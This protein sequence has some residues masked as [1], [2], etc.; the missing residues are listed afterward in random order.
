MRWTAIAAIAAIAT[1]TAV[2]SAAPQQQP[3]FRSG[4][5]LVAVDVS[6]IDKTGKPVD[7][8][9][10]ADF[11]L[12]VDGKPRRLSSA[13]FVNLRRTD[14][15]IDPERAKYSTNQGLK[16]GRL[17]LIVIDEGNIHKGNGRNVLAA[18]SKFIDGLN[19]SDRVSVEFVPGTGP[20][21]G[22]TANHAL[23]KELL[24]NGVGKMVEAEVTRQVGL[25]EAFTFVREGPESRVYL[26]MI[27]RECLG[28]R[29]STSNV[30]QCKLDLVNRARL[31]YQTARA[32]AANS[33][34]SLRAI[35]QRLAVSSATPKTLVLMTEGIAI[36]RD[37]A[38][39][40]WVAPLS[41]LAQIN[42][43][44][45]QIDGSFTDASMGSQSP[46]HYAD[47][48]LYKEGLDRLTNEA[49]GVVLPVAV[50]ATSAFARLDLE[51][52]GYYLLSFEPDLV[53]RD[54]K[55]HGI[56]VKVTRPGVTV[57][58]R[59]Q[60]AV[61]PPPGE[62][63]VDEQLVDALKNPLPVSD[64]GLKVTTFTYRDDETRKLKV[65]VST[66]IDRSANPAGDFV[67]GYLVT[68]ARGARVGS[69]FEKALAVP[70]KDDVGRPQRYT[71]AFVVDPGIYSVKV[72]VV[73]P[74]GR[75]GSVERTFNAKLATAGQLRIGELMLAEIVGRVARP[76][77][78]GRINADSLMAY[79]EIYADTAAALQNATVA[80]EIGKTENDAAVERATLKFSDR[81]FEG[82][83]AAEGAVPIAMLP[84]GDYIARAVATLDGKIVGQ[85]TRPFTVTHAEA[86]TPAPGPAPVTSIGAAGTRDAAGDRITFTSKIDDFDRQAVLS[87]RVVS[88]FVDRMN[89][90]GQPQ[91]PAGLAPSIAA[92][93]AGRFVDLQQAL[94]TAPAHPATMFLAG[95]AKMSQGDL[96]TAETSLRDALK[97]SPAFF[98][99]AFYLGASYAATGRDAD[100]VAIWQTALIT[101]AG[102]PFVY[103][104]LG[105][106]ML[107][108]HHTADA[109][110][111][112]REAAILWP[113]V[114]D[115]TM[116]FG[117]ALAQG[118]QAADALKVLEPYLEKHAADQDGLM[119]AMRLLYEARSANRPIDS[120]E[121][122]RA[123]FNRY[124]DAYA[125]TNGPQLALARQ[126]KAII[127]K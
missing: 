92:A 87:P 39:L 33:L 127:D 8:L 42:V 105:D 36:D 72:A 37:A 69:Q 7:N 85:V 24:A 43:Y 76:S 110:G 40:A 122:D 82:K 75:A 31:L 86:S 102:A 41:S 9:T 59:P 126:W 32:Q 48:D 108:L 17:I 81:K 61:A 47:H 83:R 97:A 10:P 46:T 29:N 23:V 2:A 96:A 123:K 112:L 88:F 68:D 117:T 3:T 14:D 19:S 38:D 15:G 104:L 45:L 25:V 64:V 21:V 79:A 114:D 95:I 35:I 5:D 44:A 71:G 74:K 115:V 56:S 125:R 13:E 57:R 63:T 12:K 51:L 116:R 77:V 65:L 107:R 26:E 124:F 101:D 98:P 50:N 93:K 67:L 60:F 78:D 54:G 34:L 66:E 100:A 1:A 49:R 80:I 4:V 27:D 106:A 16:P 121:N 90:V 94:T 62:R 28:G 58:A 119:L 53:D 18:A 99:A 91:L 11:V 22:F 118:G 20:L 73:D 52:S 113:D 109:I 6:A 84:A 103:T 111:L 89:I 120:V 30:E 55:A 70:S